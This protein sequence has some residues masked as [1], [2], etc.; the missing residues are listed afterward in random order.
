MSEQEA[1]AAAAA[2]KPAVEDMDMETVVNEEAVGAETN[3]ESKSLKR[4]SENGG[5]S[6]ENVEKK[7]K[8]EKSVEEERLEKSDEVVDLG[9]KVDEVKLGA[10]TFGSSVEMFDYFYKFLHF[11][12][13]NLNINKYEHM[14]LLDLLKKGHSEADRKIGVGIKSFQVRYHP[15]YKSRC[16]FLVRDDDSSDDFSFRKCIDHV[17]PLPENMKV[18]SDVNKSLGGRGS[19]GYRGR[20]RG[21]GGRGQQRY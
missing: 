13:P 11:W 8:V 18:K 3:G 20:G 7:Q 6:D 9:N 21:R 14:M 16:F 19:G 4:A 1:A 10:K 2:E 17:L 15:F 5:E 12:P